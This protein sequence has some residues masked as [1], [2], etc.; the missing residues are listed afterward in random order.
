M[1]LAERLWAAALLDDGFKG[2]VWV[3]IHEPGSLLPWEV[4]PQGVEGML[5]RDQTT[6]KAGPVARLRPHLPA[7]SAANA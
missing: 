6:M 5:A 1:Q 3:W 7:A 4:P 2:Q